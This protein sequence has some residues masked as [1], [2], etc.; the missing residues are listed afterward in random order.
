[1]VG[2]LGRA[3]RQYRTPVLCPHRA[4]TLGTHCRVLGHVLQTWNKRQINYEIMLLPVKVTDYT[5][6][7]ITSYSM[8]PHTLYLT[9]SMA[10]FSM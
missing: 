3:R 4:L 6:N 1:M 2:F 10:D 7:F 8:P 5:W 9:L